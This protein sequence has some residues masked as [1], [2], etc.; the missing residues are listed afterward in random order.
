MNM[1]SRR[2]LLTGFASCGMALFLG[3]TGCSKPQAPE[4]AKPAAAPTP[5]PTV[6]AKKDFKVAVSIYAGWMPW[7]YANEEGILKKWADKYGLNIKVEYM[8]YPASL[9]AFV[10]GKVDAC[11][12][13]NME[14]LDMP[15]AAGIDTTVA[16]VGDYS[17]GNDAIL[18][19]KGLKLK[20]I[21]G[22]NVFL[23]EKT[24]SQY[25]FCRAL[26]IEK[27]GLAEKD[28]TI[29]NVSD[30]DIAP[31]FLASANQNVVVTWNPMVMEIEK[32]NGITKVF[33]SSMIPGEIQ[34]LMVINTRALNANEDFA[35]ALNGAWYEVLGTMN[36]RGPA[37]DAALQKMADLAKCSLTEFK[38]QLK[39]TAMFYTPQSAIDFTNGADIKAKNDLVRKFCFSHNLLGEGA[40]S[41]DV[42]GIQ[43]PDGTIQG[44]KANVKLRYTTKYMDEANKGLLKK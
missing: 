6:A 3:L 30:E 1:F 27:T 9:D 24:V 13:T 25:M 43:Y 16:I 21:Q 4:A 32:S 26:E 22:Q 15:A 10:A 20:D 12:M 39:T 7:Y 29:F 33:D 36:S 23:V 8:S 41:V 19:R 37:T 38:A 2:G 17:N 18:T 42:V 14:A 28:V 40:P 34:D 11:V 5:T 35:R 44:D 31:S